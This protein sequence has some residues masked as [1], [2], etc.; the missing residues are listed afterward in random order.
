MVRDF[1]M[2][3]CAHLGCSGAVGVECGI[4]LRYFKVGENSMG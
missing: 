3:A 2:S 4:A 1:R